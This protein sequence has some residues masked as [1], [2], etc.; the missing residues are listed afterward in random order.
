MYK[1]QE[2]RFFLDGNY[3]LPNPA[4]AQPGKVYDDFFET[5]DIASGKVLLESSPDYLYGAD[6]ERIKRTLP[7]VKIIVILRNPVD[8]FLSWFK[9]A[10]QRQL[11]PANTD[12]KKFLSLQSATIDPEKH[13]H[14]FAFLQGHY[15]P[16][17][18]KFQNTFSGN[19]LVVNFADLTEKTGETM[20][21]ICDYIGIDGIYFRDNVFETH[22]RSLNGSHPVLNRYYKIRR[23]V[24]YRVVRYQWLLDIFRVLNSPIKKVITSLSRSSKSEISSSDYRI[25]EEAYKVIK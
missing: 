14:Q 6:P 22:N 2:T 25:V 23:A 10:K 8:R 13:V 1:R 17:V 3:P 4:E 21:A 7:D 15:E 19:L 11:I 5:K 18:S 12:V 16:F 24:A 20:E 9:Y